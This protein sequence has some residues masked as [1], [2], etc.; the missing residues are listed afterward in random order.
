MEKPFNFNIIMKVV[1]ELVV[2]LKE[3]RGSTGIHM[4]HLGIPWS[5][6]CCSPEALIQW[7][8]PAVSNLSGTRD[9]FHHGRQFFHGLGDREDGFG[10]IQA[11]FTYCANDSLYLQLL[12]APAQII[13]H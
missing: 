2:L 1:F 6:L 9:W 12:S 5:R 13:R 3:C 10:L 7:F 4:L 8:I 11:Q